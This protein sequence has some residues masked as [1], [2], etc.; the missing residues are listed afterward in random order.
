MAVAAAIS[1]SALTG[2]G[3]LGYSMG[4]E[5]ELPPLPALPQQISLPDNPFSQAK[6]PVPVRVRTTPTPRS[7]PPAARVTPSPRTA[8]APRPA[9]TAAGRFTI[10]PGGS[11]RVGT[12]TL[13]RYQVSVEDGVPVGV[14]AFALAVEQTLADPRSWTATK[15]WS[16]QRVGPGMAADF[17]VRLATPATVDRICGRAGMDT[18]GEVSCQA[19]T[20]VMINLRRWQL[21]IPAYAADVRDYQHLVINH[22]VGHFLGFG[23]LGCPGKGKPAPAMMSQYFGL[24]GCRT[25]PWPYP[26]RA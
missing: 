24:H 19:G 18:M 10:A 12:G 5:A 13:H 7:A 9:I 4:T 26:D 25:N 2:L 8:S 11:V 6:S 20:N 21:A 3:V 1:L 14:E 23:H 15:R 22:E 16:F 17:V